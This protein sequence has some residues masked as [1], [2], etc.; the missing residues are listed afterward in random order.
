MNLINRKCIN[1]DDGNK[2][3]IN[4]FKHIVI[5]IITVMIEI[6]ILLFV[7][8]HVSAYIY[9]LYHRVDEVKLPMSPRSKAFAIRGMSSGIQMNV[10]LA[11]DVIGIDSLA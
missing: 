10:K 11:R 1:F 8:L 3:A 2:I 7:Q 9:A 4:N 6:I 5:N